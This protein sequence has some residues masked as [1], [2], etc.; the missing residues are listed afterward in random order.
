MLMVSMMV[1][2]RNVQLD[3]SE[4]VCNLIPCRLLPYIGL[5]RTF[6]QLKQ[7]R[8]R[9][10]VA[11]AVHFGGGEIEAAENGGDVGAVLDA[12]VDDLDE[13]SAGQVV[14]GVAVLLLMDK[15]GGRDTLDGIEDGAGHQ[16]GEGGE[17]DQG[18]PVF[19]MERWLGAAA[20]QPAHVVGFSPDDVPQG[21]VDGA[22]SA[23]R[24]GSELVRG[25]L[26]A[27][28]EDLRVSPVV[29][30]DELDEGG[31]GLDFHAEYLL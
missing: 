14:D 23:R 31:F 21:V 28:S 10:E 13:E 17:V 1:Y 16:I 27:D 6:L 30:A 29:V 26:L 3:R 24:S 12:V 25:E 2:C 15:V 20:C 4:I 11:P 9:K 22:V 5:L 19:P 18:R 7:I 8:V